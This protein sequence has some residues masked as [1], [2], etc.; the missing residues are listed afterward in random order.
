MEDAFAFESGVTSGGLR[1][2][3]RHHALPRPQ[4][5]AGIMAFAGFRQSPCDGISHALEHAIAD[6]EGAMPK[7][8]GKQRFAREH[9]L[10]IESLGSTSTEAVSWRV[11]SAPENFCD[12][13]CFLHGMAR[14]MPTEFSLDGLKEVL[15]RE[16][17]E[18]RNPDQEK[19]DGILHGAL[20]PANHPLLSGSLETPETIAALTK[21]RLFEHW[22]RYYTL[23]NMALIVAGSVTLADAIAAAEAA[24][25]AM[26]HDA[27]ATQYPVQPIIAQRVKSGELVV[28]ME[29]VLGPTHRLQRDPLMRLFRVLP[30]R[31]FHFQQSTFVMRVVNAVC[32]RVLREERKILYGTRFGV[33]PFRDLDYYELEAMFDMNRREECAS[34]L[35]RLPQ[36]VKECGQEEFEMQKC[37]AV[38]RLTL[39]DD[40]LCALHRG[41][42]DEVGD[43]DRILTY[44]EEMRVL[45]E[46]TFDDVVRCVEELFSPDKSLMVSIVP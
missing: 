25:P 40:A 27:G 13:L 32:F 1:V 18:T 44:E 46:A 37:K 39:S 42:M 30:P 7:I 31:T 16:F 10:I 35:H 19:I 26:P 36:L 41:S 17:V 2:F 5:V 8:L 38:L 15:D 24:F 14:V 34:A 6:A 9:H 20:V 28:V 43:F 22:Q 29:D 33:A 21:E 12:A 23:P 3:V 45:E 11:R 4:V